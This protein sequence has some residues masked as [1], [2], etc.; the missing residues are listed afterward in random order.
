M[1]NNAKVQRWVPGVRRTSG[2]GAEGCGTGPG[3]V[4]PRSILNVQT[5]RTHLYLINQ[6]SQGGAQEH[7]GSSRESQSVSVLGFPGHTVPVAITQLAAQAQKQR[8]KKVCR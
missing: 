1:E 2:P 5:T 8:H 7:T 4:L 3:Q 6:D